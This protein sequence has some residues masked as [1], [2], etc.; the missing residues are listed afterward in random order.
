MSSRFALFLFASLALAVGCGAPGGPPGAPGGPGAGDDDDNLPGGVNVRDLD[1][2]PDP[3]EGGYQIIT[4]PLTLE[5]YSEVIWCYYGR[6]PGETVGVQSL[7][8][9][10]DVL[11]HHTLL[12]SVP[13]DDPA[14]D[15][16]V[17]CTT[18]TD[19]MSSY[20]VLVEGYNEEANGSIWDESS[21]LVLP[22]GLGVRL[23]EG[24]R[25]VVDAH[26]VNVTGNTVTTQ[27]AVNMGIVPEESVDQ[28]V[29]SWNHH[30][31]Q[32][33]V[34][35]QSIHSQ[36]SSCEWEQETSV[37]AIGGH[38]HGFGHSYRIDWT[39]ASDG[40]TENIYDLPEWSLDFWTHPDV[41]LFPIGEIEVQPGD[42]F[43][44]TC[45]WN[46]TTD[47][48][49]E[50]PIEMCTTFGVAVPLA[51]AFECFD[52]TMGNPHDEDEDDGGGSGDDDDGG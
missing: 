18:P 23:K 44:S 21:W 15:G 3:P 45:T 12:K 27:V 48:P 16:L 34:P 42:S 7:T 2:I 52:G 43:T 29:G 40:T 14:P 9:Y 24:A 38:M 35:P 50:F 19:Q 8:L 25:W 1:S 20:A 33:S 47:E 30:G 51:E 22:D 10:P 6:W 13:D 41:R 4:P 46:N 17:D 39:H 49:L 5:P 28:W 36:S 11:S 37:I 32:I 31:G 26:F